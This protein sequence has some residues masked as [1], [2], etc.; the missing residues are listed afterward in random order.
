[1][2]CVLWTCVYL[3]VFVCDGGG[4]PWVRGSQRQVQR[5][6][7]CPRANHWAPV[8]SVAINHAA[9][10]RGDESSFMFLHPPMCVCV[11]IITHVQ[12]WVSGKEVLL[13]EE[14]RMCL[15]ICNHDSTPQKWIFVICDSESCICML[16]NRRKWEKRRADWD[17]WAS[18][19]GLGIVGQR[20]VLPGPKLVQGSEKK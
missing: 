11:W 2:V 18:A 3:C 15:F 6:W 16:K 5:S 12:W 13:D 19:L 4:G 9:K 10:W 17:E 8:L 1:M 7:R 14:Y 20:F